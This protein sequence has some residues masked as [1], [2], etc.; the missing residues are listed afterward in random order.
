MNFI[1]VIAESDSHYY[2]S[3]GYKRASGDSIGDAMDRLF[4][5]LTP[6]EQSTAVVVIQTFQPDAFFPVERRN[7]LIELLERNRIAQEGGHALTADE[8]KELD[9]LIDAELEAATARAEAIQKRI[10]K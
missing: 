4:Q 6:E 2:A 1:Q 8:G 5:Q 10:G 7:R 3:S 9:E